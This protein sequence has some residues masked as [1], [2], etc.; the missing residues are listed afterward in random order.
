MPIKSSLPS[1]DIYVIKI[2]TLLT[3]VLI[4]IFGIIAHPRYSF[5]TE[6]LHLNLDKGEVMHNEETI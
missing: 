4:L 1:L 6:R 2:H 3:T 5:L